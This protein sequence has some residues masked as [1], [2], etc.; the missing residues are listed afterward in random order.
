MLVSAQSK[1][2]VNKANSGDDSAGP[3][4]SSLGNVKLKKRVQQPYW[5][6]RQEAVGS[7]GRKRA[8]RSRRKRK[9]ENEEADSEDEQSGDEQQSADEASAGEESTT[10]GDGAEKDDEELHF[11]SSDL[12][13][14]LT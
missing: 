7:S 9:E 6:H 1:R 14:R 5:K 10:E 4:L 13:E 8:N 3:E 2:K 12:R 11:E